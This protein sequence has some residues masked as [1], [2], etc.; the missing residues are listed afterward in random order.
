MNRTKHIAFVLVMIMVL[1]V[2]VGCTKKIEFVEVQ[3][4]QTAF[5][6]PLEGNLDDQQMFQSESAVKDLKV[7]MKRIEINHE[8]KSTGGVGRTRLPDKK[9]ILVDRTAV[10]R[11]WTNGNSGTSADNQAFV[12]ESESI[13]Y[14]IP[15]SITAQIQEADAHV[16]LY[17]YGERSLAEVMDQEIRQAVQAKL[18]E[19]TANRT[20]EVAIK[21]KAQITRAIRD[22][23]TEMFKKKGISIT[24]IGMAGEYTFHKPEIQK[25]ID[26]KFIAEKEKEADLIKAQTEKEK[27]D[28]ANEVALAKAENE[29]SLAQK[30][31]EIA[32]VQKKAEL[33]KQATYTKAYIELRRIEAAERI[34]GTINSKLKVVAGE[35][36][37]DIMSSVYG[38]TIMKDAVAK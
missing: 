37:A 8:M 35:D 28:K 13:T 23:V 33:E 2:S 5:V 15:M 18:S 1:S 21:E 32:K 9:V 31:L 25:A 17:W 38:Y 27:A 36:S 20:M 34:A 26:K 29:L 4:N 16:Y 12:A 7:A 14:S 30:E 24:S 22:E 3:S 19:E 6:I 10:S 11:E